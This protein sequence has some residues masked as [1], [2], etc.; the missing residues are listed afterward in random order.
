LLGEMRDRVVR[1]LDLLADQT[2]R[3][4]YMGQLLIRKGELGWSLSA[5]VQDLMWMY[6]TGRPTPHTDCQT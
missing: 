1:A 2:H 6:L 5:E 3:P 4:G